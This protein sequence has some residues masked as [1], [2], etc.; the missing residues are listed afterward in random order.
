MKQQIIAVVPVLMSRDVGAALDFYRKLG[1]ELEFQD[2]PTQP[3]YAGILR[4]G[5][6]LHLQWQDP[7]HWANSLDR[8]MYRFPVSDLDALYAEFQAAG[9]LPVPNPSPYAKPAETPWG[10]REFHFYDADGNGLQ[11]VGPD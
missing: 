10:T 11:F 9:A 6:T 5:V 4:D 7:A 8:P 3:R 1:F 2:H